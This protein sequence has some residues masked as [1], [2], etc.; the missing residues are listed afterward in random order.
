MKKFA[1]TTNLLAFSNNYTYLLLP[2]L[3]AGIANIVK[4]LGICKDFAA[5][6][7]NED[8]NI[9]RCGVVPKFSDLEVVALR[10]TPEAFGITCKSV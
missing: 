4:I 9:P 6:R 10:I 2:C 7:V 8:G 3:C 5:N 1:Y